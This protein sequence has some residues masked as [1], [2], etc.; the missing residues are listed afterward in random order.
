[1][2]LRSLNI[3]G[4]EGAAYIIQLGM[5]PSVREVRMSS[6]HMILIDMYGFVF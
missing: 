1:M 2:N 4:L 5:F 6:Y 3:V